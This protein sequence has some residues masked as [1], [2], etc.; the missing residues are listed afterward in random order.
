VA[1]RAGGRP[2][3]LAVT[4][5]DTWRRWHEDEEQTVATLRTALLERT[6]SPVMRAGTAGH[7]VLEQ[8]GFFFDQRASEMGEG[9]WGEPTHEGTFEHGDYLSVLVDGDGGQT[10]EVD[11]TFEL[12]HESTFRLMPIR[13]TKVEK[14]YATTIGPVVVRG[15]VDGFDGLEVA[16]TKFTGKPDLEELE[17]SWQWRLYL[18]MLGARGF[19]WDVFTMRAPL[20]GEKAWRI[21][22]HQ[23]LRQYR[24]PT[25]E[26]DVQRAVE[27]FAVL[28]DRYV[29][30]YWSRNERE[31]VA[32]AEVE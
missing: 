1:V 19:R 11:L 4:A 14:E 32:V 26:E 5:L 28:V 16:D 22:D 2:R 27:R 9:G 7:Q 13:E 30:Q 18:D 21:Q 20:R 8:P 10:V 15:R 17:R 6:Q 3:T 23:V 12:P 31:A 25:L 24:Y 29:P